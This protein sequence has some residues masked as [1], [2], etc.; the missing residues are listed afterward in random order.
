MSICS[1][2]IKSGYSNVKKDMNINLS[3]NFSAGFEPE[4]N[5]IC[6]RLEN[7]TDDD[8]FIYS[9]LHEI[10]HWAQ[11]MFL[12]NVEIYIAP[13]LFEM[14]DTER[15]AY[16]PLIEKINCFPVMGWGYAQEELEWKERRY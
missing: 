16:A 4:N 14:N 8:D 10:D 1:A 12:D 2:K 13:G 9:L 5:I 7:M 11:F 3:M 15:R 6:F